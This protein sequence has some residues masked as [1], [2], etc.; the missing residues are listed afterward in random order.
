MNQTQTITKQTKLV[1]MSLMA[2]IS[3]ALVLLIRIPFPPAPFLVYD[4][5][6]IPIFITTFAFGPF[7][8]LAVTFVVSVIQ[9]F[10]LT[11][12]GFIGFLM[13]MFATGSF[14][15]VSGYIYNRNKTKKQAILALAAGII[16]MTSTMLLW[17]LLITPIYLGTPRA[18][19]AAMIVPVLLPFNLLKAGLN[20]VITFLVYKRIANYLHK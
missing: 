13:H 19:V 15:I 3:L 9:A 16:T 11:G 4:P 5:A 8:G 17:N 14:V 6:D 1:K 20:S 12:D 10:A 2:A 18:A 7:A